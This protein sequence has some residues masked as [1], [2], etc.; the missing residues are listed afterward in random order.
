MPVQ[1]LPALTPFNPQMPN[2]AGAIQKREDRQTTAAIN[3]SN[4]R[5]A[6]LTQQVQAQTL[7]TGQETAR[8]EKLQQFGEAFK[9]VNDQA[10]LDSAKAFLRSVTP[11]EEL[12]NFDSGYERLFPGGKYNQAQVDQLKRRAGV[13][14]QTPIQLG[15]RERL[16]DPTTRETL[17]PALPTEPGAESKLT[18]S[19]RNPDGSVRTIK[20]VKPGSE[21]ERQLAGQGFVR[22]TQ[23]VGVKPSVEERKESRLRGAVDNLSERAN[24]D[25]NKFHEDENFKQNNDGSLYL[26]PVSQAPVRMEAFHKATGKRTNITAIKGL[27]EQWD[28]AQELSELL[29]LPS[30]QANLKKAQDAGLWDQVSGKWSNAITRWMQ[31]TG[32]SGD[33][34][35]ATAVA[36]IQ[37]MA[38][39]ERKRFMGTAVT[40]NEI[41]SALAWMPSPGDSFETIQNKTNLMGQEAEQEFR[42]WIAIFEDVADMSPFYKAFGI[43]RFGQVGGEA[44]EPAQG[45]TGALSPEAQNFLNQK[46]IQ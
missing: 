19:K 41:Q 45:Q 28:D 25:P 17:V 6:D 40:E 5:G 44:Q 10:S 3:A 21:Q 1:R 18:Y 14:G 29:A 26:D 39:E 33:S 8:Q 24:I 35:T 34:P 9:N 11:P 12:A 31:N 30:V 22:G 23:T 32:I 7:R 16:I 27:G 2:V 37:R 38:S 46:G 42:R 13:T 20:N 4:L 15:A 36:R 43:K